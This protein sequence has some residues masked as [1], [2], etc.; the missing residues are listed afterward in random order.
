MK[1][2]SCFLVPLKQKTVELATTEAEYY[3]TSDAIREALYLWSILSFVR[4][5]CGK[6]TLSLNCGKMYKQCR[7]GLKNKIG[8]GC[9]TDG[10]ADPSQ[11]ITLEWGG[12]DSQGWT[13]EF[14]MLGIRGLSNCK[15]WGWV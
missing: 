8:M 6:M 15:V 5:K 1:Q 14:W 7:F 10:S 3:A 11:V 13:A 4:E 12:V 9:A 2:H